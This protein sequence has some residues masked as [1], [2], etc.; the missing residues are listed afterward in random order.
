[1]NKKE[2]AIIKVLMDLKN[3]DE[4]PPLKDGEEKILRAALDP[5]EYFFNQIEKIFKKEQ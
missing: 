4:L 3:K 2:A 1:M 5:E